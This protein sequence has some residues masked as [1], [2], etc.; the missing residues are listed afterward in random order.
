MGIFPAKNDTIGSVLDRHRGVGPGFD[1][2]RVVL[3]L[4]VF[5]VHTK[6]IS[7][8][9]PSHAVARAMVAMGGS[10][11]VAMAAHTSAWDGWFRPILVAVL[12]MFFAL[13]GFLVAG[14]AFRLRRVSTFLAFRVL[15]LW[16]ALITEITL[17]ALILGPIFTTL[18]LSEYAAHTGT[19]AYFG[20]L[21][22]DIRYVLP[23]VFEHQGVAI[24]NG[25]LRT[26]P[27]EFYCYLIAALL[28][29]TGILA[30][31][32]WFTIAL[33]AVSV[34][35]IGLNGFSNFAVMPMFVSDGTLVYYFM[36]GMALYHWRAEI[37][38]TMELLAVAAV[39][40]FVM[41]EF[42]HT[43][44]LAAVPLVYCT[45]WLGMLALPKLPII[46]TGD[47]SYG[48]YL[49]G[50]PICQACV[51]TMP[52]LVGHR[53]A[54][55]FVGVLATSLFAVFS[56]HCIEKPSLKLKNRLPKRLFAPAAHIPVQQEPMPNA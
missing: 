28:M 5:Y 22:G 2:L 24:V 21:L 13:S 48:I 52:F 51:A 41:L 15:R 36:V 32:K 3:A 25:N 17:S 18:P 26:L 45:V 38:L 53:V 44:F 46:R 49:Y 50:F 7:N 30:N 56:W 14:S 39:L 54:L 23:G 8:P 47:Y 16:P 6:S 4:M 42:K 43:A 40:A 37:P 12:P 1:L 20:N 9:A 11:A 10:R 29:I 33:A 31:R 19:W 35:L 55:F 27:A 34:V